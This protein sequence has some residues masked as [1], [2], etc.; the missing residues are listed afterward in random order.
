MSGDA[1]QQ[2][3]LV[4]LGRALRAEGGQVYRLL[5]RPRFWALLAL[6]L[7]GMIAAYQ[8]RQGYHIDVGSPGDDP[9]VLNFHEPLADT[10]IGRSY[11]WTDTYSY[12]TLP[13]IGGGVPYT[14][15]LTLNPGRAAVPATILVNGAVLLQRPLPV[16]RQTVA[17]RVDAT[18]PRALASRDL[19]VE[20]RVPPQG[21]MLDALTVSP[22]EPGLV[23]PAYTQ[24]V[25]GLVLLTLFYLCLGRLAVRWA[26]PATAGAAVMLVAGLAVNRLAITTALGSGS[27][28]TLV[29]YL[30]LL[31]RG[32]LL[33]RLWP[34]ARLLGRLLARPALW[35]IVALTALGATA[36]YQVRHAYTIEVGDLSDQPYV[37]HY[38]DVQEETP[39]GRNFRRGGADSYLTLPG[40]GGGVPYTVTVT[41]NPGRA[42]L[43]LLLNVNGTTYAHPPLPAGWQTLTFPVDAAH[44]VALSAPDLVLDLRP[45]PTFELMVDRI[46]V[47]AAGPGFVGPGLHQLVALGALVILAYLLLGRALATLPLAVPAAGPPFGRLRRTLPLAVA[48]LVGAALVATLAAAHLPLTAATDH[49]VTTG[50]LTYA[51]LVIGEPLARR[52]VPGAPEG[53]R[54]AAALLA[55]A[56]CARYGAM[57]LP[58]SVILDLGYHM[59]WLRE[60]LQ[61]NWAALT[62]PHGGLNQPPRR[63]A[64]AI[65]I[66]KSALFY[67]LVAPLALLPFPLENSN[68]ALICLLEAS[69]VLFCYGLLARFAPRLGGGVAGLWAGAV[70]ALNPLGFRA[71]YFGIL[72]TLLDQWLTLAF[73]TLLLAVVGRRSS[74]VRGQGSGVRGQGSDDGK[75]VR[76]GPQFIAGGSP[77][78]PQFMAGVGPVDPQFIVGQSSEPA[79]QKSEFRIQ[80]LI[81][82]ALLL[83]L[84]MAALIGFPTIALF[85]SLVLGILALVWLR[86][87]YRWAGAAVGGLLG[88]AWIGALA[89]YYGV[90][91]RELLTTTLPQLLG[92]ASAAR[93]AAPPTV[94][95]T[96]PLDLLGWT[97]TYLVS[98]VPLLLGGG[99]LLLLWRH[100]WRSRAALPVPGET[101]LA[102]LT[103]AWI[104]ILPLFVLVNYRLDMIGKHLFYTMVPLALGGGLAL[105]ALAGRGRWGRGLAGGLLAT[106]AAGILLFWLTTALP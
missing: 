65:F 76:V 87:R 23:I 18:H 1:A 89:G 105:A 101:L 84:L 25:Y 104:S 60:L 58:Q 71:L 55:G 80:N 31:L 16:G 35:A 70:A 13:G 30:L 102:A 17:L 62:D 27:A 11:R 34:E 78:D 100:A 75:T 79:T 94:H 61:G 42:D 14:V 5:A 68:M 7:V 67:I 36:A 46:T 95:W 57:A 92:P 9:Y 22:P 8:V 77:V 38:R 54:L 98:P 90:Y 33:R 12:L 20:I 63:W 40:L 93:A 99:G 72:P 66:P 43:P 81:Y 59:R 53:A 6:A 96:D 83:G 28:V 47:S 97:L 21:I 73:F 49:L 106:L 15:T 82:Y 56:F 45:P 19:V 29:A 91:I 32:P 3:L 85:T 64:L 69:T 10:Q 88:L 39:G 24:L 74:G 4:R 50:L 48:G 52:I 2:G 51:L 37:R 26:L 86:P 103:A 41:L 44:S